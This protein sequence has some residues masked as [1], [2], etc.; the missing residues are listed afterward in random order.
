MFDDG[1]RAYGFDYYYFYLYIP[2]MNNLNRITSNQG[3]LSFTPSDLSISRSGN[4]VIALG[5]LENIERMFASI[6][7]WNIN[8]SNSSLIINDCQRLD[9]ISMNIIQDQNYP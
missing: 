3:N 4:E 9:I 8:I 7:L 1:S 5:Y 6:C 2:G